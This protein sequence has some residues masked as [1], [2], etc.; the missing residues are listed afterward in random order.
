MRSCRPHMDLRGRLSVS[1]WRQ[2]V[3]VWVEASGGK[4]ATSFRGP[5]NETGLCSGPQVH[6]GDAG[7]RPRQVFL[8]CP[9]LKLARERAEG[10]VMGE[11]DHL[12]SLFQWQA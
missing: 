5:L 8:E 4:G 2:F 10:S 1:R 3:Q 11:L 9:G 7:G 6:V 12:L